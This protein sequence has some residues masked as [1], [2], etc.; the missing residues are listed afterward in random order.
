MSTKRRVNE[1]ATE[2]GWQTALPVNGELR[3]YVY[4]CED[5]KL[6]AA[7][8]EVLLEVSLV[9]GRLDCSHNAHGNDFFVFSAL[10]KR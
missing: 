6:V 5:V 9:R 3:C 7:K 8:W 2:K 10:G 4:Q 1:V